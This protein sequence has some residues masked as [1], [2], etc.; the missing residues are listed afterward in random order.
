MGNPGPEYARTRH[1]AGWILADAL[2]DRWGIAFRR[3]GRAHQ[4]QGTLDD[5]TSVVLL[6]PQTYMNRSGTALGALFAEPGF[7]PGR[8]L[9][10]VVDDVALP[11]GRF[12][13]RPDGS[14]GGHN[15]LKSIEAALGHQAWARLRIGVGPKPQGW[16]LADYVLDA[17]PPDEWDA[18][19]DLVPTLVDAAD[20]W[21]R[22]GMLEAMNRFNQPRTSP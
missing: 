3:D 13:F 5:G 8:D 14:A 6:K 20:C 4:A 7:D 9:L 22:A 12:R 2:A 18:L 16:D 15:G 19:K 17:F 10:V 21:T 1:N 11:V